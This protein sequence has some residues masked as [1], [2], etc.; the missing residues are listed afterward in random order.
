MKSKWLFWI[1]V[2]FIFG[3][4][5]SI[6]LMFYKENKPIFFIIEGT[7][8][9]AVL[10]FIL[11][12]RRL[13]KPY[14]IILNGME[15]LKEQDFST[16]LRPVQNN[17]ANNLIE[18]F[19][20]MIA[21]LKN[22][23]RQVRER[24]QF[25]DLLIKAIPQGVII[26]D[27]DNH[28]TDVNPAGL[29]FLNIHDLTEV[30]GKKLEETESELARYL[31][32]FE[33]ENKIIR[34]SDMG[35]YHCIRAS[36]LDRG[37][38]RPF[39]LIEEMTHETIKMEKE[40]YENMIRMMSHEVNNSIGAIGSTLDVVA[41]II[42]RREEVSWAGV[43]PAVEASFNRCG[44]LA[45]FI[46]NLSHMVKIPEPVLANIRIS[47]SVRSVDALTR[48]ECGR[49][50]IEL[51]LELTPDDPLIRA[52]GILLEQV[53]FN[54]VKNAYESIGSGGH[55]RI[56]TSSEPLS[57][58]IEDDGPGI[59]ESARQRLFTPFFTTKPTGQGVG[60]M[61]VREVLLNHEAKFRL[62]SES[63]RTRFEIFFPKAGYPDI[64][65]NDDP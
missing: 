61:F 9:V 49:R 34:L 39:I 8:L 35:V 27:F 63:G 18:V 11:L 1:L 41:D 29:K 51:S 33:P 21:Q 52:D 2:V 19:N 60:L 64:S 54:L 6:G 20:R 10:L 36:F 32:A 26:L 40:T 42:R 56:I 4:L 47:E 22:E 7:A 57:I 31:S 43:L 23:R 3:V 24:N 5:I 30:A 46:D 13:I 48:A 44:R 28:I 53:L 17:E 38:N 37:F 55:I 65:K 14:Q 16:S 25:L 62:A 45:G 58:V 15:L 59:P 50:D 12:Y